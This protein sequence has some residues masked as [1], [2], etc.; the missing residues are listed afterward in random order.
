M[1]KL[2]VILL[3]IIFFNGCATIYAPSSYKFEP[4]DE[5][6]PYGKVIIYNQSESTLKITIDKEGIVMHSGKTDSIFGQGPWDFESKTQIKFKIVTGSHEIRW[7]DAHS[8]QPRVLKKKFEVSNNETIK[9]IIPRSPGRFYG[10]VGNVIVD[11]V[12]NALLGDKDIIIEKVDKNP[13]KAEIKK[14]KVENSSVQQG[15][16]TC[17]QCGAQNLNDANFCDQCGTKLK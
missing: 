8:D 5:F 9:L 16:I 4:K 15:F 3:L 12:D 14:K 2:I 11:A 13:N 10:I 1:Q 7:S 6:S 17:P